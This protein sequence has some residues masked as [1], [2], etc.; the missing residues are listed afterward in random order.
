MYNKTLK[1]F[2]Y[3]KVKINKFLFVDSESIYPH[4]WNAY[5]YVFSKKKVN[6]NIISFINWIQKKSEDIHFSFRII[7]NFSV[8]SILENV[9]LTHLFHLFPFSSSYF[10]LLVW[11]SCLYVRRK[12]SIWIILYGHSSSSSKII[13]KK[14]I[15]F[16][17]CSYSHRHC[18]FFNLSKTIIYLYIYEIFYY[19]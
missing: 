13:Q 1:W 18:H 19:H 14:K 12:E 9:V 3:F 11:L 5:F 15:S 4:I 10:F 2:Q 6:V 16:F 8:L 17:F 7:A